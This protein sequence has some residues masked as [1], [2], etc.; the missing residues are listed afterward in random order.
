MFN[1]ILC[2]LSLLYLLTIGTPETKTSQSCIFFTVFINFIMQG[3]CVTIQYIWYDGSSRAQCTPHTQ[4]KKAYVFDTM[5]L[6]LV[7]FLD[8]GKQEI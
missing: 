5:H 4:T 3:K 2:P 1:Y 6:N 8:D 7:S